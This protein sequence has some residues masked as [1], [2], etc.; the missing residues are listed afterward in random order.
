[1]CM[2]NGACTCKYEIPSFNS[3]TILSF[4][5]VHFIALHMPIH[6]IIHFI[7]KLY[8]IIIIYTH[9]TDDAIGTWLVTYS[10]MVARQ[11][12]T[13]YHGYANTISK[14]TVHDM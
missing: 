10:P 13:S 2:Y 4:Y 5:T 9:P 12:I 7:N 6:L 14:Y 11:H 8:C 1:M 3:C